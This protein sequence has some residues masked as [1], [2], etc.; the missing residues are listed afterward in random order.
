MV[1]FPAPGAATTGFPA[2]IP[3]DIGMRV[4]VGRWDDPSCP[5]CKRENIETQGDTGEFLP[6]SA[7]NLSISKT[8]MPTDDTSP[9]KMVRNLQSGS[10]PL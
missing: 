10:N 9:D 7:V 2:F 1:R 8:G 5:D 6:G 4:G 3:F